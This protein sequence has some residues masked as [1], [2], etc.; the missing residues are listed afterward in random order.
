MTR[1]VGCFAFTVVALALLAHASPLVASAQTPVR[2][3]VLAVYWGSA[4]TTTNAG[5]NAAIRQVLLSRTDLAIDYYAEYLES[6]RLSGRA[7]AALIDT[8]K[9]KYSGQH[10][11]LVIAAADSALQF[12]LTNRTELFPDAP[13]VFAG[14]T[15]PDASIRDSGAGITGVVN[16]Q[17]LR[18]TVELALKLHPSTQQLYI[19]E[20]VGGTNPVRR[21]LTGLAARVEVKYINQ[22]SVNQLLADIRA[23]PSRSIVLLIRPAQMPGERLQPSDI[24]RLVTE[25]SQ[26]PVYALSDGFIGSGIVGTAGISIQDL[27]TQL[28]TI[29]LQILDGARAQDIPFVERAHRPTFDWRQL[30]HWDINS[31]LLPQNSDIRFKERTIWELYR[32]YIIAAAALFL[33]QAAMIAA[34]IFQRSRRRESEARNAGILRAVP[35]MMFLLSRDGVYLDSHAPAGSRMLASP[36]QFIGNHMRTVFPADLTATFEEQFARLRL[37]QDPLVVEYALPSPEGERQ[38]EARLVLCAD[39]RVLSMVRDV[40]VMKQE[41]QALQET[42]SE[43]TRASRMAALGE[44]AAAIAHEIRQPLTSILLNAKTSLQWLHGSEPNLKELTSVLGDV[45]E[46]GQRADDIIRRNHDLF[47]NRTIQKTPLDI[48]AVIRAVA[49]LVDSRI[50]STHCTVAL[51]LDAK[52]P[53]VLGDR[54][55][56][57]QV[58]LNLVANG[59][60]AME[61]TDVHSRGIE[62]S[63][64]VRDGNVTVAVRDTGIGLDGVDMKRMFTMSYT[65][66]VN[67]SGIGLSVSRKIIEAHGG[68]MWAESNLHRGATFFFALPV[69]SAMAA[70]RS[71]RAGPADLGIAPSGNVC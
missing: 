28:G 33:I 41:A 47:K 23:I 29:A 26:A 16:G 27:G 5:T 34:L 48:N 32:R 10:I 6:D 62:I 52:G 71:R 19:V 49:A 7:V 59:L 18:E 31:A 51:S 38:Y 13:I 11:D 35:D 39:N 63:S 22:P 15:A 1:S 50:R 43:L 40:T 65:T 8:I 61:T 70:P 30:Q 44:F 58:L 36:D 67:G 54:V 56:L 12:V 42:Q 21:Q 4:D 60:D 57:Q 53:V 24:A 3:T 9:Q 66:K 69:E 2:R 64:V 14:V 20:A 45:L 25:N 68:R 55:E 37:G 46:A 17:A